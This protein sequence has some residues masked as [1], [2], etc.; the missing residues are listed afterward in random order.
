MR[1]DAV[2]NRER[3]I[4]TA[5][6]YFAENGLDAPMHAL[7]AAAKVGTGTLYRNFASQEHLWRALYDR[8]IALFDDI[9]ERALQIESGWEALELIVDES[10][11]VMIDRRIVAEVMRRLAISDPD[12]RPT[13]R[14]VGTLRT[15]AERAVE[16]GMARPDL[17][18]A[19]LSAAPLM[20]SA[21]QTAA[22]ENRAWL[23]RRM[24]T[25]L[26]DGMRAHPH[27]ATPLADLPEDFY[28]RGASIVKRLP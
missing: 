15:V 20:L 23:A 12:Y 28:E 1:R 24:R 26:L 17:T 7:A 10:T 2:A 6:V 5:E 9:A 13:N 16:E 25:L 3:I 19:D 11:Q 27:E 8:H 14:W 4:D 18:V 21:V 22:P